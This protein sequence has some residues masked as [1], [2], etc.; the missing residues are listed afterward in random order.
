MWGAMLP[1]GE[2]I[3]RPAEVG[4]LPK[5]GAL[6]GAGVLPLSIVGILRIFCA[7]QGANLL[8]ESRLRV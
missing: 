6:L 3:A 2:G 7:C 4:A 5:E 1:S 8:L